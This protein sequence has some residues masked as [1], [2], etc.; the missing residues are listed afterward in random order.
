MLDQSQ[1]VMNIFY[2][3]SL[4][5]VPKLIC[6]IL[7]FINVYTLQA[8]KPDCRFNDTNGYFYHWNFDAD[9]P[10]YD[11]KLTNSTSSNIKNKIT[12]YK[13]EWGDGKTVTITND[14]FPRNHTYA[15]GQYDLVIKITYE[16]TEYNYPYIVYNTKPEVTSVIVTGGNGCTGQKFEFKLTGYESNPPN[17]KYGWTF[18]DGIGNTVWSLDD[19]IANGASITHTYNS[20]S[21]DAVGDMEHFAAGATP[22][23]LD[24]NQ[25]V[26]IGTMAS[27]IIISKDIEL[28]LELFV[29]GNKETIEDTHTGCANQTPF[30]FA[31]NSDYGLSDFFCEKTNDHK[32]EVFKIT[33]SNETLATSGT[34]Y[35]FTEGS[36]SSKDDISIT[37]LKTGSYRIRFSLANSCSDL[38]QE[39]G[40]IDI[41]D[42]I[43]TTTYS[44]QSFCFDEHSTVIFESSEN[45]EIEAI[46]ETEYNWTVNSSAYNFVDETDK[47][48]QNPHF[49]FTQAGKFTVTLSKIS[50]CGTK[51]YHYTIDV[52]DKPVV[53]ID[54]LSGLNNGGH[55]GAFTFTPTATYIDNGKVSFGIS[56]NEIV[57]YLWTFN[58]NGIIS[59]S[60]L[61]DPAPVTFSEIGKCS[62]SLK[63]ENS[64]CGWSDVYQIKFDIFAIPEPS[65]TSVD[66]YCEDEELTYNAFPD[67]MKTY[68]WLF[69]DKTTATEQTTTHTYITAGTY[70]DRLTVVSNDG[71]ANSISHEISILEKA[72][73]E[74][75]DDAKICNSDNSYSLSGISVDNST[76]MEWQSEGDGSFSDAHIPNP[77][78]TLGTN[79]KTKSQIKLTLT[80]T[81]NAPC[82][83]ESDF[84]HIHITPEPSISI[85]SQTETICE[86]SSLDILGVSIVNAASIQ[87][88]SDQEGTFS[89]STIE[90]PRFTPPPNFSGLIHLTVKALANG[91]CSDTEDTIELTVKALPVV[92]AGENSSICEDQ[93]VELAGISSSATN[94]WTSLGD[95]N[96][97]N[98]AELTTQYTPGIKDIETGSVVLQLEA[99]GDAPCT[100]VSDSKTI[101]IVRKVNAEA[102]KDIAM[103][104]TESSYT[105]I[106]GNDE[107]QAN[108][109]YY[110]SIKWTGGTGSF[111]NATLINTNYTPS[112]ADLDNGSVELKLEASPLNPC[113]DI[114]SDVM[115]LSF[116]NPPEADAGTDITQCQNS[117]INLNGIVKYALSILW[118]SSGKGTFDDATKSDAIY[119]PDLN[120]TGIIT[121]SLTAQPMGSCHAVSDD[122]EL[123]LIA[124]PVANAG[125][126]AEICADGSY[127]LTAESSGAKA[128]S[129]QSAQWVSFGDGK[130]DTP[131]K[132]N[133][134]YTPGSEDITKRS[135]VL[136][137][138]AN[139]ILPCAD[140]QS[141]E[142]TLTITPLAIA[143]AGEN[144]TICQGGLHEIS[145]ATAS[146]YSK[147]EW[148]TSSTSGFFIN[149]K[150]LTP[151]YHPG[152]DDMGE[153]TLSLIVH[154]KGSCSFVQDDMILNMTPA[155]VAILRDKT[156]I[157]EDG[158]YL[159]KGT[160]VQYTP[161]YNWSTTGQGTITNENTLEPTYTA[162]TGETGDISLCLTVQ[163]NGIC[164][165]KTACTNITIV[166]HPS[167]NA[168]EDDEVCA[169]QVYQMNVGEEINQ[170]NAKSWASIKYTTSGDGFFQ[171]Q[172]G[173]TANY[174]PGEEDKL[175]GQV[176]LHIKANSINPCDE[177]AEDEMLLNITPAPEVEAG[178]DA[179][180]CQGDSYTLLNAVEQNT[181]ALMWQTSDGGSFSNESILQPIYT[182]ANEKTG[183]VKLELI[184]NG[185][186]SCAST[187]DI[188]SLNI[189]PI[190]H[191]SAGDDASICYGK[192]Y[193][194][195]LTE[196]SSFSTIL[197][198]SSGTGKFVD[199]SKLK[200]TYIPS[201]KDYIAGSV[202]LKISV[203]GLNPCTLSAEDEML[204]SFVPAPTV[205]AGEDAQICQI[206]GNYTIKAKSEDYPKGS[207][208]DNYSSIIW[209]T[210]GK[211]SIQNSNTLEPTYI[212]TPDETGIIRLILKA[213]GNSNCNQIEDEMQLNIIPTP[214]VDFTTGNSCV[215][216]PI[217]FEDLSTAGS[218]SVESWLWTFEGGTTSDLRNPEHQFDE[219]KDY[220]VSLSITNSEGC[221]D[222]TEKMI[223][224]NPLPEM[225]FTHE[226][227]AAI[228]TP[229][230]FKNNCSKAIAY[231]WDFGDGS[232]STDLDPFH[233]FTKKGIFTILLIAESIDGCTNTLTSEIVIVGKPEASFTRTADGCGP[234]S[235]EF[236]N[237]STGKHVNY[238]WDF[239]NGT[240]STQANPDPVIYEQGVLSDT[241]YL[242]SLTIENKGGISVFTDKINVKPLP[243]PQFEILPTAY[244][245]TPVV[246]EFFNY[247]MGLPTDYEFDFGDKTTYAYKAKDIER[248]FEH[249][250]LTGDIK[251]IYPITLVATNECGSRS[252]TKNMT[253]YPNSAVA[254]IKVENAEGC[255]PFT[256]EFQ[257]LST[258]AGDYLESDWIFED[259][260]LAIRDYKGETVYHTFEK[261]GIYQVLLS[262]HDTCASDFTTREIIVH[263]AIDIDFKMKARKFCML[264]GVQLKVPEEIIEQFTN[265]T[266]D[267]GDGTI[268]KGSNISHRY[269]KAGS[270]LIKLSAISKENSCEKTQ[271]K[272]LVIH[273][274]PIADYSLS[275]NEGCE[276]FQVSFINKSSFTDYYQ[277]DF[278]DNSSSANENP[279]HTFNSGN[280]TVSLIAESINGCLDTLNTDLISRPKP[281]VK[282]DIETE[283]GCI[284]P[285][286]LKIQNTSVDK[287]L[288]TYSWDFDNGT[289]TINS[290][291]FEVEYSSL[292]KY[293]IQ[294]IAENQYHCTD[295]L[296]KEFNI[297]TKPVPDYRL[298]SKTTC[299][300][301]LIEFINNSKYENY[302]YWEFSDGFTSEGD[303]ASHI[304]DEYG[305]YDLT[306]KVIGEGGCSDSLFAE[307]ALNV[308][309]VPA[310]NFT[311]ENINTLPEGVKLP[312]G[313]SPPNNGLIQFTNQT[314]IL[315]VD[316]IDDNKYTYQWDFDDLQI[317]KEKDPLHKYENNGAFQINLIAQSAYS[318][319]NSISKSIDVDLMSA[320]YVPNA[321]NPGNP[322]PQVALFL[323][324]GIGLHTYEIEV[325]DHWGKVVWLSNQIKDG[326]PAEGWDG[327][328]K[329]KSL[330]QGIYIWK[331]RAIFKN[332]AT[333][334]GMRVGGKY[335]REGSVTLIK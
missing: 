211:G 311:W 180:I 309:P 275:S 42:N 240:H 276:P 333:W 95:G 230:A 76:S 72:T 136:Q 145:T 286:N 314:E 270:Y 44:P 130:F 228:N 30:Y 146:N 12:N 148:K 94:L 293:H 239:G 41:Y 93:T 231:H 274:K 153:T 207:Q 327:T 62:I 143:Y 74:A 18:G 221:S 263:D 80:A 191:V 168:G 33:E 223:R 174:I 23:I 147:L 97:T 22:V 242:V 319:Q 51:D 135:V 150:T 323:P 86:N 184:G 129:A 183:I 31:N 224:V 131:N 257:N 106:A 219:V 149:G 49:Q 11:F 90:N 269:N 10:V 210:S 220:K 50:L 141:D 315:N 304:F 70:S 216:N 166:P 328:L 201:D 19:L 316:W 123:T 137:L 297:Y 155:P 299:Q 280:Y 125:T 170:V 330:P 4:R 307:K 233:I 209:E 120:E 264:E 157:C 258:G 109:N 317:C 21:C 237:T 190:P 200:A 66:T 222:L 273:Q 226:D 215:G 278:N 151:T 271:S 54:L 260:K 208:A 305:Q 26:G 118:T 152:P 281:V 88:R 134:I 322:N 232:T 335:Y 313:I 185:Q 285:Y 300:G 20:T 310:V 2:T 5:N 212:A 296:I 160:V 75:G 57:K 7:L 77:I 282:F 238:L 194:L 202:L 68:I 53:E 142:M 214:V 268:I 326:R 144:E 113:S 312:N 59:T 175:A 229:I 46:Q 192:N 205:Y 279:T 107:G 294:L 287:E 92:K 241:T 284:L 162:K 186:G 116:V 61:R 171:D 245:C 39:T 81:G 87:W 128:Y 291:P 16:G 189:I 235:V 321:F 259:G 133:A 126:N 111:N 132:L 158:I 188:L 290:D 32:W 292:G 195:T 173:L 17:T 193:D 262:V 101:T 27:P 179:E 8:Q 320:L 198:T 3:L 140:S 117:I 14:D 196:A 197:W 1:I 255:V 332:G 176:K 138:T 65:F 298:L 36:A 256:V 73:V 267:L 124:K 243:I 156:D 272:K 318:C 234:L 248:P 164:T 252:I 253:V 64:Q 247:S 163:G 104:K 227:I 100:S 302:T 325:L 55:C 161:G 69:G 37:F 6:F 178:T 40:I 295:T 121:L 13:I 99:Q 169:N 47:T 78:Y 159:A 9:N 114:A 199:E 122:L 85:N 82:G 329:G 103:C 34:E 206:T 15:E 60:T 236:T 254:V 127:N 283:V 187:S 277:W 249:S 115:T 289:T 266:W 225:V 28:N 29:D 218:Y 35:K 203:G 119:T 288:N 177:F 251:S 204:L 25:L 110:S 48:S 246:R 105:I 217:Q 91:S 154:G 250:F 38:E 67:A 172:M 56:N 43:N 308:Y 58:N 45:A 96:F 108:A 102:G 181:S 71:C 84:M 182:P 324:K 244:G 213:N 306:L 265:F 139:P 98:A 261:A 83:E 63:A 303:N 301:E 79:D 52:S 89:N 112:A 167:V 331:I 24:G 334:Q 165:S